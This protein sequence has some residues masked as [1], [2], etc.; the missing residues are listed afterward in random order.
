MEIVFI[1]G[2]N[3]SKVSWNWIG[4]H[5]GPQKRLA[6]R[7]ITDPQENIEKMEAL[8]PDKCLLVGHS[9]GGLY[10]WHLAA[11]NPEKVAHVISIGT[12]FGGSIQASFWKMFN[13]NMPWLKMI[14]RMEP[15]TAQT[16]LLDLPAPWTNVVTTHGLDLFGVGANDGVVTVR[17]QQELFGNPTEIILDYGHTEVLQSP[18]LVELIAARSN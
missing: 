11:R 6:W 1:H 10:A 12:P 17:S 15:W 14:S 2:A 16:R 18:E 8:L 5:F 4:S 3:A 9:M 7:M 13:N